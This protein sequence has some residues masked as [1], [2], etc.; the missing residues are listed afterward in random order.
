MTPARFPRPI[1]GEIPYPDPPV[2]DPE[3][4]APEPPQPDPTPLPI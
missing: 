1:A 3:P 2:P 4:P